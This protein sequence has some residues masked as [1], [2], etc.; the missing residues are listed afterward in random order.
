[1]Q[2]GKEKERVRDVVGQIIKISVRMEEFER[3]IAQ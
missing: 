1:M 2:E 3:S